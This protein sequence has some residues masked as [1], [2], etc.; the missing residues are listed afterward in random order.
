M[1]VSFLICS[2][3]DGSNHLEWFNTTLTEAQLD[4]ILESDLE[5]YASGDG[6]QY[7]ELEVPDNFF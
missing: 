2:S 1:K 4:Q 7:N 6:I 5:R 3:G